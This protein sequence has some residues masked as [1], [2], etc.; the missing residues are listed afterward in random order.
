MNIIPKNSFS[1]E[2][3][4]HWHYAIFI[5]SKHLDATVARTDDGKVKSLDEGFLHEDA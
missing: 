5:V 4:N 2:Y 1:L 3:R